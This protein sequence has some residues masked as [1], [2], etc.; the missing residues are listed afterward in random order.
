VWQVVH[1]VRALQQHRMAHKRVRLFGRLMGTDDIDSPPPLALRDVNF[2][3]EV[4]GC[5]SRF[6]DTFHT[7]GYNGFS[8]VG[9]MVAVVSQAVRFLEQSGEFG[10]NKD[11][12]VDHIVLRRQV[13][14]TH[15][16]S[17]L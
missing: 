15:R 4:E 3:M 9:L 12:L 7:C 5:S 14:Q 10:R 17:M 2:L 16:S 6:R 11:V 13:A 8:P 1:F